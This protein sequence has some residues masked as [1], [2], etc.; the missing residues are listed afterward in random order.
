MSVKGDW[1][2]SELPWSEEAAVETPEVDGSDVFEA[3]AALRI[4]AVVSC[5][6]SS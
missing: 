1:A 3:S 4:A 6:A 2:T 5:N